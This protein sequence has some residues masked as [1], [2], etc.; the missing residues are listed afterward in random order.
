M[1]SGGPSIQ[2]YPICLCRKIVRWS[3]QP[4]SL[5]QMMT[6]LDIFRDV[7]LLELTR[8][9]KYIAIRLTPAP[10]K[11]DLNTSPTMQHLLQAK[12]S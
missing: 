10:G 5:G 6:C 1:A 11:A 8:L 7:G 12:E 3:N 2:E 9:H 4:L